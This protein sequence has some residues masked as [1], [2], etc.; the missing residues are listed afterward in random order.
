M[1]A[2][3]P[4]AAVVLAGGRGDRLGGVDKPGISIGGRTLA[5]VAAGAALDAGAIRVVIVG[6]IRPELADERALEFTTE[7]P[8]GGGP[9]P[10]LRAGLD[11][12]AEPWLL[13]LAA[14]LPFVTGA[15]LRDLLRA[16]AWCDPA[17]DQPVG[18]VQIDDHEEPQWLARCWRT[19]SLPAALAGYTGSSLRGLFG[20]L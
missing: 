2:E 12:V 3:P 7:Q 6:P 11:L 17:D 5:S 15:R 10:A 9:V 4:L 18:A 14:D 8:P 19:P 13:L 20:P 1:G 16:A